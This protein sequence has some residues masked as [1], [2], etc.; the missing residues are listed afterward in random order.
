[1]PCS[2]YA[3]VHLL[4]GRYTTAGSASRW[5]HDGEKS[6]SGGGVMTP[7]IAGVMILKNSGPR[8]GHVLEKSQ[9]LAST[10]APGCSS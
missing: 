1:M 9:T 8:W 3:I 5:G 2:L 10:A 7:K 6:T 4:A